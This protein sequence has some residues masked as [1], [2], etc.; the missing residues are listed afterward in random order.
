MGV[1]HVISLAPGAHLHREDAWILT[2]AAAVLMT[3]LTIIGFTS[4][5]AQMQQP[6]LGRW[7]VRLALCFAAPAAS[8]AAKAVL[9]CILLIYLAVLCAAQIVVTTSAAKDEREGESEELAFVADLQSC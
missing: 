9:P 5:D 6:S 1:E 3:A 2:V 7:V 4:D 8:F